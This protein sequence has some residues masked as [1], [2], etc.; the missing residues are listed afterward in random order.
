MKSIALIALLGGSAVNAL[1][2]IGGACEATDECTNHACCSV[3]AEVEAALVDGDNSSAQC[4][5][6]TPCSVGYG[7]C[8]FDSGCETGLL[9]GHRDYGDREAFG[10]LPGITGLG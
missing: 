5:A 3:T 6:D 1:T 2:A 4:D 10:S 7:D 8:N 9:C